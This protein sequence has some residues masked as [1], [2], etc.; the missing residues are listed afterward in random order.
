MMYMGRHNDEVKYSKSAAVSH[1]L[2]G[3][4]M[5]DTLLLINK[6]GLIVILSSKKKGEKIQKIRIFTNFLPFFK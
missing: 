4:E 5:T 3:Y 6:E 1:W 2:T